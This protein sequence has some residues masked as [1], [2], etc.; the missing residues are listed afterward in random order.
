M[1]R[2]DVSKEPCWSIDLR[3]LFGMFNLV[4]I[5]DETRLCAPGDFREAVFSDDQD[6]IPIGEIRII[7]DGVEMSVVGHLTERPDVVEM[8]TAHLAAAR[9][10]DN[11]RQVLTHWLMGERSA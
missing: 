9:K 4:Y 7:I 3:G 10:D 8:T 5:P 1:K 2:R 11:Y 6:E